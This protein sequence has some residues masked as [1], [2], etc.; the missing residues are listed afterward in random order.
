M[1]PEAKV[2]VRTWFYNEILA[3][4]FLDF[5][6]QGFCA[7]RFRRLSSS[8][9][10]GCWSIESRVSEGCACQK[11]F[12]PAQSKGSSLFFGEKKSIYT[13]PQFYICIIDHL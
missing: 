10:H 5:L 2:A 13:R 8:E 1:K 6:F 11:R 3:E 4:N 12:A 9:R 7:S